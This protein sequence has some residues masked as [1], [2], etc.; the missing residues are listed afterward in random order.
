MAK[1]ELD[2]T[3][4]AEITITTTLNEVTLTLA[5]DEAYE[6]RQV[7]GMIGGLG[8]FDGRPNPLSRIKDAL[9]NAGIRYD[10][11]VG[12]TANNGRAYRNGLVIEGSMYVRHKEQEQKRGWPTPSTF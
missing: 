6:L 2:V 11:A 8:S 9:S 1:A 7:L 12:H 10:P 3:V 5:P 4:D